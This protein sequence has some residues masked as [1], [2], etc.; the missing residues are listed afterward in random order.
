MIEWV[1]IRKGEYLSISEEQK[2]IKPP[3]KCPVEWAGHIYRSVRLT[4][5]I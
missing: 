3:K 5:W 2:R 1:K 4:G